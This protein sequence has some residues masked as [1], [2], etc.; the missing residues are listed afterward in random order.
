MLGPSFV[1]GAVIEL[2][3][4]KTVLDSYL[5]EAVE[6]AVQSHLGGGGGVGTGAGVGGAAGAGKYM[7]SCFD[8]I[9]VFHNFFLLLAITL[10]LQNSIRNM[11]LR[12]T[13]DITIQSTIRNLHTL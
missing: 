5:D 6:Q 8:G 4:G 3:P 1:P 9:K 12:L 13:M 11:Y 7:K 10:Q 2:E